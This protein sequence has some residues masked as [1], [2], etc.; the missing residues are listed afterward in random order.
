MKRLTCILVMVFSAHATLAIAEEKAI[1]IIKIAK[2]DSFVVREQERTACKI[3]GAVFQ[4]DVLETDKNGSLGVTLKDNTRLSLGPSSRLTLEEFT[5]NPHKE[6]YSFISNMAKGTLV[7]LSGMMS[8]LS[9][10]SVS[11]KTPVATV[12]IRGTRF[13]IRIDDEGNMDNAD[14]S[15]SEEQR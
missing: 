2:G 12:G 4:R 10:E 1:G 8:K 5:F 11:V 9:P 14:L 13:L 6:E 15:H 3:G 7:Y